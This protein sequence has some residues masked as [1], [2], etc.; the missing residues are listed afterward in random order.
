[1]IVLIV[2]M[3]RSGTSLVARGLHAM[4]LNL[5]A[6]VDTRPHPANPHGHWEHGAVWN[7]Q[8]TLLIR[9]GREWHS[10]PGPLPARWLEWPDT[11]ATI[12]TFTNLCSVEIRH[13]AHW[14]VK[15][16]RTSLLLPLWIE[17]AHRAG[18]SLR[19]IRLLRDPADVAASLAAR[20]Q[21]PRDLALRIW[22]DHDAAIRRDATGLPTL[23]LEHAE[24]MRDP[25]ATFTSLGH[26]CGLPDAGARAGAAAALVDHALWHHRTT[27]D[28][29][30]AGSTAEASPS[31]AAAVAPPAD[32]GRVLVVM[33]TRWRLHMLPRGL[34]SVLAQTY[35]HWF[36]AIVN[37]GGPPHA[38]EAEVAPYR[39]VLCDRVGILHRDRQLGMEAATNAAIAAYGGEFVAI[40][41]DDDSWRPEFLER[42]VGRL[43]S[44]GSGAAVCQS[45][46]VNEW[47]NGV[48]HVPVQVRDW[49]HLSHPLGPA[50]LALA[51][52]FPPISLL[53]RRSMADAVG[54]FHESLP[55]L[56]DWHFN[57]RLAAVTPIDVVPEKLAC[58]HRR[59]PTGRTPNSPLIDHWRMEEFVRAW[60]TPAP[61]PSFF[62]QLRQVAS[63]V[64]EASLAD[65]PR[66]PLRAESHIGSTPVLPPGLYLIRFPLT[67]P[68][69]AG[70]CGSFHARTT[71]EFTRGWSMP[72]MATADQV[73]TVLV[74]APEPLL[75][76]G[77]QTPA[78]PIGPLPALSE[79]V[80]L[81]NPLGHLDVFAGPPRLPDVLC[82][83]A[84]RA[85]TTW[86][87]AALATHPSI[88][89]AGIKEVHH[90]DDDGCNPDLTAFRQQQ[91][92]N[93]VRA[94]AAGGPDRE[95]LVRCGLAHAFPAGRS[96]E[97][98]AALFAAAPSGTLACDFTPAYATLSDRDVAGIARMMP[99]ARVIFVLRDP[100]VRAVSG[101]WHRLRRAGV[102]R[103]TEAALLEACEM[104]ENLLRTDY[105]RTLDIWQRHISADR[106]LVLF[107]DDI[108]RDPVGLLDR[109]CA[110]LGIPALPSAAEA[111]EVA[112]RSARNASRV[113]IP[114]SELA[115]V[116]AHL[117]AR[118]LP[119]LVDL[120][121]RLGEPVGHWRRAAEARLQA[122]SAAAAGAGPGPRNTVVDNLA[123]W[124]HAEPWHQA[125]DQWSGQARACG[126][127]YDDWKAGIV[128]RYLPHVPAGG[129]LLEIGP[130]H[131]RWSELFA[132]RAGELVL[133]DISPN[134]LDACRERL[135]G[136]VLLRTHLSQAADLPGD[137]S[138][139]VD[140]VWSYDC[141][142]HVDP[143]DVARYVA[144][145]ARVLRPGGVAILHHANR[146]MGGLPRA[147]ARLRT[148]SR[149][150]GGRPAPADHG[151]RSAVSRACVAR[152]ARAAGLA[153]DR[154]D[155]TWTWL[156]P[157]GPLTIGV[158]R[159]GDCITL[160]RRP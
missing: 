79:A 41:D 50:D 62:S 137:L 88:W 97:H 3:H 154:V 14:V 157:R 52:R 82:I 146:P 13:H 60:P 77:L 21:M 48:E 23:T 107:H 110:F 83:G 8:E 30:G 90:F 96:W 100:V 26:W 5:G 153:V 11:Q 158:P 76:L 6:D 116:K 145:V 69:T 129:R 29:D 106:L 114:A 113:P 28:P 152:W 66:S 57:R 109:T 70:Q 119:M 89:D 17:V 150:G 93:L 46:V 132:D 80:R 159:F 98:Y 53:V 49:D 65:L 133:C 42:M 34:R 155:T 127:P 36:L 31:E 10:S 58:W 47:W 149:I 74:N 38:V 144:E 37:D 39:R 35:P 1:M 12:D 101:G 86:L 61:L 141:L 85:G 84:Q 140:A 71:P 118:W 92:L 115:R 59:D 40:H 160:L 18:V 7:A 68:A 156:S 122:A 19:L 24:L 134:C 63:C 117:S 138:A 104:P 126:V 112:T 25:L 143:D 131:G 121:R 111:C 2:G 91:G 139:A 54:P 64:A 15:D 33:R 32:R 99:D 44:T 4:G 147:L 72:L 87:H 136:R 27:N 128:A 56:G 81:G 151:W 22:A 120:E 75:G 94:H 55:A 9:F 148:I 142:V 73:A 20:N 130:G 102:E 16:P 125:G 105:T 78:D 124:D 103:P 43:E 108:A 123:Q 95:P 135:A 51:N 67:A 45:Q